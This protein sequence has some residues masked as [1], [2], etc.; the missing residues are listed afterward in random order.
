MSLNLL[1]SGPDPESVKALS[2]LLAVHPGVETVDPQIAT[3][4]FGKNGLNDLHRSLQQSYHV[5]R[6]SK[7]VREFREYARLHLS[8]EELSELDVFLNQITAVEYEGMPFCDRSELTPAKTI[9][10]ERLRRKFKKNKRKPKMG[11]VYIPVG[12]Q[13]FRLMASDF[14]DLLLSRRAGRKD[15]VRVMTAPEAFPAVQ[16]NSLLLHKP[17]V[18]CLKQDPR[19]LYAHFKKRG[20][21][22]LGSHPGQFCRWFATNMKILKNEPG[23]ENSIMF[24]QHEF[25]QANAKSAA[26]MIFEKLDISPDLA[27]SEIFGNVTA[28]D[29]E[30]YKSVCSDAELQIIEKECSEWIEQAKNAIKTGV[31]DA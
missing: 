14:V 3:I 4:L 26:E 17:V 8:V 6:M 11:S 10:F 31:C 23:S 15:S 22:W 13:D 25:V 2:S 9:R 7:K 20:D 19:N 18:V 5:N 29:T 28:D 30:L 21:I 27:S 16:F 12:I 1:L 24:I